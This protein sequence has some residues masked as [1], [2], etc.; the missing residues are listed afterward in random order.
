MNDYDSILKEKKSYDKI[1][2]TKRHPFT[3]F[4]FIDIILIIICLGFS[5]LFYYHNVLTSKNILLHDV[6][7]FK[8]IGNVIF[9]PLVINFFDDSF[10]LDGNLFFNDYQYDYEFIR[11]E[12]KVKLLLSDKDH[13]LTYYLDDKNSYTKFDSF[14]DN[15]YVLKAND[16]IFNVYFNLKNYFMNVLDDDDFIKRFYFNGMV[17]VVEVNLVLDKNQLSQIF[18]GYDL[19]DDWEYTLTFKNNAITNQI[20]DCKL[21][22]NNNSKHSRYVI[23]YSNSSFK[24]TDNDGAVTELSYQFNQNDFTLKFNK[25]GSVYSIFTGTKKENSYLYSYQVIDKVYNLTLDVGFDN[26]KLN[27]KFHSSVEEGKNVIDR[28]AILTFSYHLDGALDENVSSNVHYN[29]LKSDIRDSFDSEIEQFISPIW[30]FVNEYKD[31][32]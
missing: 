28:D 11:D 29:S 9:K 26:D 27:Y 3:K 8:K 19:R 17:P 22:I 31:S 32:I 18:D 1:P 20:I 4:I 30:K 5:Y 10:S 13:H 24:I 21:V 6:D 23:F 2:N 14:V 7:F 12:K 16:T 25:E 15:K